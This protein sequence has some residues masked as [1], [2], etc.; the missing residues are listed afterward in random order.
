MMTAAAISSTKL[1]NE[2]NLE[3]LAEVSGGNS[4]SL[5]YVGSLYEKIIEAVIDGLSNI[6]GPAERPNP[7][8]GGQ[9]G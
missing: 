5:P 7:D 3:H 2:L 8:S 9:W 1:P 4:L 6:Q